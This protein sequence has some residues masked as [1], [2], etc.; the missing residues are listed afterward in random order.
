[1]KDIV[2][3]LLHV[4]CGHKR[5]AHLPAPFNGPYWRETRL[6]LDPAVAPD[7][8]AS[9]TDMRVIADGS[10]DA[11][12]SSHN[13]EHLEAH[14]LPTALAEIR[15][16]LSSK[17]IAV[18][19]VPDLEPIAK[20]ILAGGLMETAYLSSAGPVAPIDMLYGFRPDLAAGNR[21]MAHR[22][23]FTAKS[24]GN[25]LIQ[26]G[27]GAASV[28]QDQ[29]WSLWAVACRD[30]ADAA[31]AAA[32]AEALA[33]SAAPASRSPVLNVV[34]HIEGKG[35]VAF[36]GGDWAGLPGSNLRIE[37]LAILPEGDVGP[38][39]IE[40]KILGAD[41]VEGPWTPAGSFC[42]TR[43]RGRAVIGFAARL[44]N[45]AETRYDFVYQGAFI[46]G[47]RSSPCR[48]GAPCVSAVAGTALEGLALSLQPKS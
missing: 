48:N 39:D 42:G 1:M 44:V 47:S 22:T 35:D 38:G 7:V 9:L 30:P 17:G 26:G 6:D 37:G 8:V 27:F 33:R 12:F 18:V 24:L 31:E 3:N 45:G 36:P 40:Y 20:A 19:N 15:R 28:R 32:L 29:S 21:Y 43:G 13:L 23:G 41:G 34:A 14:E 25:A 4:G 11:V 46:G 5:A 2:L 16:V 10:M